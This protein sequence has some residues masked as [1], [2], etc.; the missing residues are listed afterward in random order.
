MKVQAVYFTTGTSILFIYLRTRRSSPTVFNFV[1]D[2]TESQ[3]N[4]KKNK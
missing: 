1:S 3:E 4:I 2:E